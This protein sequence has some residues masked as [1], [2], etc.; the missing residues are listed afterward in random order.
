ME[1]RQGVVYLGDEL[2]VD[3]GRQA[4]GEQV[5]F[6]YAGV[7]A[8]PGAEDIGLGF[9]GEGRAHAVGVLVP[10]APESVEDEFA[11]VAV[12]RGAPE[13]I[14]GLAQGRLGAVAQGHRRPG[15]V[16]VSVVLVDLLRS[17]EH[18][19]GLG[20]DRL[21]ALVEGV[22]FLA[23]DVFEHE[24]KFFKPRFLLAKAADVVRTEV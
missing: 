10:G 24:A 11:V 8:H 14:A 9:G 21:G 22:R 16:G 5:G 4:V 1:Q 17:R 18:H 2:R 7:V 23:Q 13:G 15:D 19:A 12:R 20:E 6:E 3:L